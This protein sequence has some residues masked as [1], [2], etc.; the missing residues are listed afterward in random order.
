MEWKPIE[1]CTLSMTNVLLFCL[2]E[3][4]EIVVG[5][6]FD[7]ADKGEWEGWQYTDEALSDIFPE[8]P[9]PSHWMPLPAP[10]TASDQDQSAD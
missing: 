4:P 5:Y 6:Y 2:A 3:T 7:D 9:S 1:T 8:G 10:P